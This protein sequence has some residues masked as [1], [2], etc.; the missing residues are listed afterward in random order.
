MLDPRIAATG[1]DERAAI[2]AARAQHDR[3]VM[4]RPGVA[5]RIGRLRIR[6]L[7]PDGPGLP[8]DNPNDDAT[9]LLVS[10]GQTDALFAAD[11]ESNVLLPLRLPPVEILKVSHHGSADAGLAELLEDLRPRIAVIS[12]GADNTYGHPTAE[13]LAALHASPGLAVYRTDEDGAVTVESDGRRIT[14]ATEH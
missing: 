8:S 6:V 9:V 2:A 3:I 11:A 4:A 1:P 5:F 10:Y 13:T 12:V 7:W 14:V